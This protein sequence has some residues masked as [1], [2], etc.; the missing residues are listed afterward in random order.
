[1]SHVAIRILIV[2]AIWLAPIVVICLLATSCG[3]YEPPGRD[4]WR[5]L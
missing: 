1:M 3:H 2:A 5:A 4:I